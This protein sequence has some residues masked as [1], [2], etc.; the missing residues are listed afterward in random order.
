MMAADLVI[1][2]TVL[3]ELLE[4]FPRLSVAFFLNKLNH[5][6]HHPRTSTNT[7]HT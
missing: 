5:C 1:K 3:E 2:V 7:M 4:D 6:Q